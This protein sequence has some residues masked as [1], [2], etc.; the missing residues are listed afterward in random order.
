[1]NEDNTEFLLFTQE[2]FLEV[3]TGTIFETK[4][5][6]FI[7]LLLIMLLFL[8]SLLLWSWRLNGKLISKFFTDKDYS[9]MLL[10]LE[11]D[12]K[13]IQNKNKYS[14]FDYNNILQRQ[15]DYS[16]NPETDEDTSSYEG[17]Y[18][19]DEEYEFDLI[20]DEEEEEEER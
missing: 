8:L 18:E 13:D 7:L 5:D 17:Y 12:D 3:K 9:K 11:I 10:D 15:D 6:E 20:S 14:K 16:N 19:T 1:M 4:E 2:Q